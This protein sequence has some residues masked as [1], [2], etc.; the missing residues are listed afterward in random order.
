MTPWPFHVDEAAAALSPYGG[1]VASAGYIITL[2]YRSLVEI[3]N[4]REPPGRSWAVSTEAQSASGSLRPTTL[5]REGDGERQTALDQT[6]S[7][8]QSSS[9]A[10]S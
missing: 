2:W 6:W 1:I 4:T 3:Y 5:P 10:R 9:S 8:A 7:E